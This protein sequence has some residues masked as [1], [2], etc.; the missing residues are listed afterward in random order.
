MQTLSYAFHQKHELAY[1]A[2]FGRREAERNRRPRRPRYSR[3]GN[4]PSVVNGIQ[5]RR[6]QRWLW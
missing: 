3:D 2:D 6:H 4:R 1:G 5:R